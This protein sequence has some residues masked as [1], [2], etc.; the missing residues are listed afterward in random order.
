MSMR[1]STRGLLQSMTGIWRELYCTS[2]CGTSGSLKRLGRHRR[3]GLQDGRVMGNKREVLDAV[4]ESF[5]GQHNEGQ[6]GLGETTQSRVRALPR[7][8]TEEQ[9]EPTHRRTVTLGE[10]MEAVPARKRKKSPM[11]DQL[12]A[13]AYQNLVAPELDGFAGRVTEVLRTGKSPTE[14]GQGEA[15]VQEGGSAQAGELEA[16]MMCCHRGQAALDG[17]FRE[18]T[19]EAVCGGGCTGQHVGVGAEQ[20][21]TG[22]K[23]PV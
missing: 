19:T 18:D 13:E 20:V 1:E 17:G 3:S 9:S 15:L 2:H 8:F 6:Q 21:R 14:W 7:V 23:L 22:S 12:V 5:R 11:E 4:L 10:K 16:P